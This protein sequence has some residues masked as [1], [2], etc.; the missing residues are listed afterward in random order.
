MGLSAESQREIR[1]ELER[2]LASQAFRRSRRCSR[3]LRFVVEK[4]LAGEAESL[5]ERTL[6]LALFDL[7]ADADLERDSSVRVCASEVRKRLATYYSSSGAGGA[8]RIELPVG[9][10]VPVFRRAAA[11]APDEDNAAAVSP[12]NSSV[13]VR[14]GSLALAVSAVSLALLALWSS[15]RSSPD[16][17]LR[18]WQPAVSSR[19][20][21][22]ILVDSSLPAAAAAGDGTAG[23]ATMGAGDGASAASRAAAAAEITHFLRSR[24]ARVKI[25][26]YR[27]LRSADA[28]DK[29]IVVLGTSVLRGPHP[30]LETAPVRL[31]L[32]GNGLPFFVADTGEMWP[33]RG[34]P[35]KITYCVIYRILPE[36]RRPFIVIVGGLDV[37]ATEAAARQMVHSASIARLVG[38]ADAGWARRNLAILGE[39]DMGAPE[40]AVRTVIV[41]LW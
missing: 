7:P 11:E 27:E 39:V 18:F 41:R 34:A 25:G 32:N 40:P 16:A 1:L 29:A 23:S 13:S 37:R 6:A 31:R 8:W 38:N 3:F 14:S 36:K 33:K 22:E 5:K 26:D 21:V 4:A 12:G 15:A 28:A 19:G 24:G 35:E 20:G 17:I 9:S 10:Y 30:W 2:I